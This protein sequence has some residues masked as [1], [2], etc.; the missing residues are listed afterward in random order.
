MPIVKYPRSRTV[1]SDQACVLYLKRLGTLVFSVPCQKYW[2]TVAAAT[3]KSPAVNKFE[4]DV[5]AS[6]LHPYAVMVNGGTPTSAMTMVG[7]IFTDASGVGEFDLKG[8]AG[9]CDIQ[10]VKVVDF[11]NGGKTILTGDFNSAPLDPNDPPE[12]EVQIENEIQVEVQNELH[13]I[14]NN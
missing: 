4:V 8:S 14:A 2:H 11:L 5:H 9:T 13:N 12:V 1:V 6:A 7:G 3:L 10:K